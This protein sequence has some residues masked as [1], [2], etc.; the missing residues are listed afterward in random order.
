MILPFETDEATLNNAG[1][2]GLNLAKLT[3]AGFPVPPGF[4]VTTHAYRAFVD[5]NK[6]QTRILELARDTRPDDP[7]SLED[8][9]Q[10][11]RHL[12]DQ[13]TIPQPIADTILEALNALS[14]SE[15][16]NPK[17]RLLFAP[18]PRPKICPACPSPASRTPSST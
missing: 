16:R 14:K 15:I 12:F 3:R 2:K 1:G 18:P 10:A 5:A 7:T 13:G 8:A 4:I 6:L 11:I 17:S 9:S